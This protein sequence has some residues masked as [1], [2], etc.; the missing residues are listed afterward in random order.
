M[1]RMKGARSWGREKPS[2]WGGRGIRS[3]F[4]NNR[5]LMP[6]EKL[7]IKYTAGKAKQWPGEKK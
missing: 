7:G 1:R 6:G 3:R 2:T 4:K 5:N